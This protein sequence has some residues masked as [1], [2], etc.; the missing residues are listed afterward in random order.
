[1]GLA[2]NFN[3][4]ADCFLAIILVTYILRYVDEDLLYMKI[5]LVFMEFSVLVVIVKDTLLR[6][7]FVD[8]QL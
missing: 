2:I 5:L 8:Q 4:Y 7:K 6:F 1:M 3:L